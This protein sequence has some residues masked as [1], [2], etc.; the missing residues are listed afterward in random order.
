MQSS[1][2]RDMRLFLVAAVAAVA[3]VSALTFEDAIGRFCEEAPADSDIEIEINCRDSSKYSEL[4]QGELPNTIP[5]ACKGKESRIKEF[6]VTRCELTGTFPDWISSL[7]EV[8]ALVV[9][10][11]STGSVIETQLDFDI[12]TAFSKLTKLTMLVIMSRLVTGD[13]TCAFSELTKLKTLFVVGPDL[14]GD[15]STAFSGLTELEYLAVRGDKLTGDKTCAF[16]E[17]TKLKFLGVIGPS[18]K[19]EI[20]CPTPFFSDSDFSLNVNEGVKECKY[21]ANVESDC[22]PA[23][24][25]PTRCQTAGGAIKFVRMEPE[26]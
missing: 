26:E 24:A 4:I 13:I 11:M 19:G 16:S 1:V 3:T 15:I 2:C 20:E 5:K 7:T 21:D 17:L 8:T 25:R 23:S 22:S 18:L 10:G 14:E 9:S 12:T 6:A